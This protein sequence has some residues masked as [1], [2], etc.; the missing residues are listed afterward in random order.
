MLEQIDRKPLVS[1]I[2]IFFNAGE[3]FFIEAIDSIFAQTYANWEL[4]L[5]DDGS[6]DES[7]AIALRYAQ[8]YPEKVRYLEHEE[9][10]NRGMSAA[11][12][13]GIRNAKGEYIAFLDADDVWLSQNLERLVAVL[14]SQPQAAM[15]CGPTPYWYSWTGNPEDAQREVGQGRN[16]GVLPNML[17]K[18][19]S[20]FILFLRGKADTPGTCSVLIRSELFDKIGGFEESFR[21]MLEDYAF[22]SKVYLQAHVFVTSECWNKYR[23]HP[24]SSWNTAFNT[25]QFHPL[26]PN[27]VKQ[28]Y[29]NWVREYL[30]KQE[31][32]DVEV[33][34]AV[35]QALWP[36][37]HPYLYFLQQMKSRLRFNFGRLIRLIGRWILPVNLR[38]W[39]DNYIRLIIIQYTVKNISGT[40]EINCSPTELIVLCVL[41]NGEAYIKSFV[42]H[43]FRAGVKHIVFLD[44]GS[45]DN[46]ITI[47]RQH[48]NVTILQ[49]SQVNPRYEI[50][51]KE[52]L[53]KRFAKNIPYLFTEINQLLDVATIKM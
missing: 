43:Y 44:C 28:N 45:T 32:K 4:L 19:P 25:G 49:F 31:V 2:I 23:Q 1:C 9:H 12:N 39:L 27:S 16:I 14:N 22:F 36:Y 40:T 47:A 10:Q 3:Q 38:L 51:L 48:S 26:K 30:S 29:L 11:R 52:Y 8:Q 24:A 50:A 33:W 5:A 53:V 18:P 17:Y 20:L 37:E 35:R 21:G 46:T 13:L 41:K 7:T 34:Q 42:E 6:T 15:V